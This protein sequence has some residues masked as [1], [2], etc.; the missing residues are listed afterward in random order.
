MKERAIIKISSKI[1]GLTQDLVKY[2]NMAPYFAMTQ[3]MID[4]VCDHKRREIEL[5]NY[6]LKQLNEK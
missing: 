1:I 2:E 3:E 4:G 6:I 5:Y